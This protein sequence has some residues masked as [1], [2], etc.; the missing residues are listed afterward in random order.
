MLD[1]MLENICTNEVDEVILAV[2][3]LADVLKHRVGNKRGNADIHYSL[4]SKPLGTGG[5]L[6]NSEERLKNGGTFLTMNGDILAEMPLKEMHE[7]HSN[8]EATV[9]VALHKVKDPS[10]FGVAEIDDGVQIKRFI[11]KPKIEEAPSK[12]INA[13]IYLMEPEVLGLIPSDKKVSLEK[14]VFPFLAKQGKLFGFK[15]EGTWFDVGSIEDYISA[16]H[17]MIKKESRQKPLLH[18]EVTIK[19]GVNL[20]PPVIIRDRVKIESLSTIGPNSVI[21][22]NSSIGRNCIL[23][24]SIIFENAVIGHSS[25]IEGAIIGGN[26]HI[27]NNVKI[28][29]KCIIGD[30]VAIHDGLTISRGA[31]ICPHKEVEESVNMHSHIK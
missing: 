9:T 25:K 8:H 27:G 10:R 15:L 3:Y 11:E 30:Y 6:K 31:V 23:K 29:Q 12:W 16:N 28:G 21:C 13:G 1:W 24:N 14:E 17:A 5:P 26:V 4:E 18:N 20:F 19:S 2:N 22:Q 7:F